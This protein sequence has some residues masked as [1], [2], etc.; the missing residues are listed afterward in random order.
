[1]HAWTRVLV[2]AVSLAPAMAL[3]NGLT[4]RNLFE[5]SSARTS[6]YRVQLRGK[7]ESQLA[8]YET[9][10]S[11]LQSDIFFALKQKGLLPATVDA[12][13]KGLL[14]TKALEKDPFMLAL[15]ADRSYQMPMDRFLN[16]LNIT[17]PEPL[18]PRLAF[19]L[20]VRDMSRE[21]SKEM[22]EKISQ[23]IRLQKFE[24]TLRQ[25]ILPLVQNESL[26]FPRALAWKQATS[27]TAARQFLHQLLEEKKQRDHLL[28]SKRSFELAHKFEAEDGPLMTP[29][30]EIAYLVQG[31]HPLSEYHI[32]RYTPHLIALRTALEL[33]DSISPL[34]VYDVM[35]LIRSQQ[36]LDAISYEAFLADFFVDPDLSE[37]IGELR[38]IITLAEAIESKDPEVFS[39]YVTQQKQWLTFSY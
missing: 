1:M 25:R 35:Q 33:P 39:R 22:D 14:T 36:R 31:G 7:Y 21:L 13:D 19:I 9:E 11:R 18:S 26:S 10:R 32:E 20:M 23:I 8:R 38:K 27:L 5:T 37:Q 17:E 28:F 29:L 24:V 30:Y 3:A 15:S 34:R 4:C 2:L 16:R 6:A 12:L